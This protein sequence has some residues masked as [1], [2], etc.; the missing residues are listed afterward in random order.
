MTWYI[1]AMMVAA[2]ALPLGFWYPSFPVGGALGFAGGIL[3]AAISAPTYDPA[4][5]LAN[6]WY[7]IA[8]FVC[9][10]SGFVGGAVI[11][12]V[13]GLLQQPGIRWRSLVW[14]LGGA[15]LGWLSSAQVPKKAAELT[16]YQGVICALLFA[17]VCVIAGHFV[18]RRRHAGGVAT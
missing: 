2:A 18:W 11:G 6:E 16:A 7:I 3:I 10:I 8:V 5:K 1:I 9:V 15:M 14:G 4:Q 17:L 13:D 12:L